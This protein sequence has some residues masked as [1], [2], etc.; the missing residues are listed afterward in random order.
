MSLGS[1]RIKIV[2]GLAVGLLILVLLVVA[3]VWALLRLSLPTMEGTVKTTAFQ[4]EVKITRDARGV[5]DITASRRESAGFALGFV[6]GQERFFQMDLLRRNAA[7]ELAALVGK[8]GLTLDKQHAIFELRDKM[9]R[10]V[11]SLPAAQR[12]LLS[13]YTAGVNT[14]LQ[15]LAA[16]PFEYW[17]LRTSPQA[18][19]DEDTLL[20]VAAMYFDLQ[21]T[22]PGREYAAGWLQR[23][24]PEQVNFLLPT[25]SRWDVPLHGDIPATLAAPTKMP[26]WWGRGEGSAAPEEGKK[27]SNGWLLRREG[28]SLLANDMHLQ[29]SLPGL[30]YQARI[31]YISGGQTFSLSGITLPGL[32]VMVSGSNGKIA[33]GFTN[34]YVDTF[35][36]IQIPSETSVPLHTL[37]LKVNHGQPVS[38]SVGQ[39]TWGP[40]VD[41][42]EGKMAMRWA[43]DLPGAINLGLLD[44]SESHEVNGAL[45]A[46][47]RAGIP[48]QNLLVADSTGN[49]GWTL[50]GRL[51]AEV[52]G[53][54]PERFPVPASAT[55]PWT[56]RQAADYPRIINPSSGTIVTANNRLL[57]DHA[58]STLG[59]GG[60]DMGVRA[61]AIQR[62]L[63][64]Q[65]T[66]NVQAMHKLQL[67]NEALLAQ[68]WRDWLVQML[69]SYQ[70]LDSVQIRKQ[71]TNWNGEA[72]ADSAAYAL[73]VGWRDKVY[74]TLFG[75]LDA[76]MSAEYPGALYRRVNTR[77]DETLLTLIQSERWIPPTADNWASFS[78]QI[79]LNVW[80][81]NGKG[82]SRWGDINRS[83]YRHPL[84]SAVPGAEKWLQTSS[85]PLSGD[86]NVIHVN[87]PA[88]G[89]SERLVVI[90]GNERSSTLALPSGQSGNPI[91]YNWDN[92]FSDWI[93]GTM[94][95][96][97]PGSTQS[98]LIIEGVP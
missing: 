56:A 69:A 21:G 67:N 60:A 90:P 77:W 45:A 63:A 30:W 78:H 9:R 10:Q 66:V 25:A 65:S 13:A 71:L 8:S 89:A 34:S 32:P 12:Q 88:F 54:V 28:K 19:R 73:I 96:L 18:W 53:R 50:A 4:G 39:S 86:N 26:E 93:K 84:A 7:G 72:D 64:M 42:P 24:N 40:V 91:S 36:W 23:H 59:D 15:T 92:H 61:F 68:S 47:N 35:D 37:R 94:L 29:L 48:A 97:L 55:L 95:P 22:Q 43:L 44:I 2:S 87:R 3:M 82:H 58:G 38:L 5:V 46:G 74:T 51:P 57:F 6:H 20:V 70:D 11:M 1:R 76:K 62:A 14:G 41:T 16:R 52:S 81:S 85:E 79:L 27:G 75:A 49:I 17:L 31:N 98:T 33:W 83:R 80:M